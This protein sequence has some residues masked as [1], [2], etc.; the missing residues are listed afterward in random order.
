MIPTH[1]LRL[2]SM[3]R[4]MLEVIIPALDP[5]SQL[6][7]DQAQ[8]LVANLHLMS[9]QADRSY[10][11]E[12]VELREY[13]ALLARLTASQSDGAATMA[14]KGPCRWLLRDVE[15]VAALPIPRHA[16]L[17][18]HVRA[19]KAA[20]DR[21]LEAA[22]SDGEP[23]YYNQVVAA[24]LEQAA[25]QNL[26]ERVWFKAAGLDAEPDAL[27]DIEQVLQPGPWAASAHE[28]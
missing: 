24:T 26:R 6:A 27:P 23:R 14:L 3:L 13:V 1:A 4:S 17:A 19:L 22:R 8:I 11:Y 16:D 21:L 9:E 18:A 20:V 15:P 7:R 28:S 25:T 5:D 12:M 10:E 2:Q